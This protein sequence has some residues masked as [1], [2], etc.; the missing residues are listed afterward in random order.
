[1]RTT[2]FWIIRAF[3]DTN[4]G[5]EYLFDRKT[6]QF[7]FLYRPL[8]KVPVKELAAMQ[9]IRYASS[10]GLEIPA[11]LTLPKGADPKNLP[12]VVFPHGGPQARDY[13]GFNIIHQF[14]AN[15]GY[16][17]LSPNFRGSTGFGKQ[18][19]NAGNKQWGLKMQDDLTWG[20]KYLVAQGI[21]DP[22]RVGIMGGSY[23]GYAALAGLAFTPKVYAAGV[24]LEGP[25]NLVT[26]LNSI[27]PYW[28][29]IRKKIYESVGDPTTPEGKAQLQRQSPLYSAGK[30]KA[31]LLVAQGANDPRVTK[32]ESDQIVIALREQGLPVEYLV[33]PNEGHG[34][35]HPVNNLARLATTEK[36]LSRHLG[37]RCQESMPNEVAKRL[38]EMRVDVKTV[39][40]NQGK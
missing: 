4:P 35:A 7:T 16:A 1:M 39:T 31:P 9:V 29:S 12:L 11:Y 15:R 22:K 25:S 6:G 38:G 8:P 2:R 40:V 32:A 18:F 33:A 20:V 24:S 14:L 28:E 17:V 13:W 27:P 19:L 37:G 3:S 10:D 5:E 36:F 30:M 23:G 34:F 26:L 21:A